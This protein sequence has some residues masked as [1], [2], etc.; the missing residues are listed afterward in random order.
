[1]RSS[2]LRIEI[3]GTYIWHTGG[4]NHTPH[5]ILKMGNGILKL[6]G[7]QKISLNLCKYIVQYNCKKVSGDDC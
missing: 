3:P 5:K 7:I 4:F 6:G 2:F 1:M